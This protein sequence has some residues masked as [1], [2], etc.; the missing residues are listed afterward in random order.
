MTDQG[1]VSADCYCRRMALICTSWTDENPGKR[2]ATYMNSKRDGCSFWAW[3]DDPMFRRS[4]MIIPGLLRRINANEAEI[5]KLKKIQKKEI[6]NQKKYVLNRSTKQ[7]KKSAKKSSKKEQK[8]A[9]KSSKNQQKSAKKSSKN[10]SKIC[11]ESIQMKTTIAN[12]RIS[13]SQTSS[14]DVCD[15]G[16]LIAE[17]KLPF[18]VG[19]EYPNLIHLP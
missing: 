15:G 2:F 7:K 13:S 14:I 9:Q 5:Q 19:L 16:T 1:N 17:D 18:L 6:K 11:T 3:K 4:K 12:K 10:S 8:F